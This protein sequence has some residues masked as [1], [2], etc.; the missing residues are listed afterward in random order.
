VLAILLLD[1]LINFLKV[2]ILTM[3][4]YISVLIMLLSLSDFISFDFSTNPFLIAG[5]FV[6]TILRIFNCNYVIKFGKKIF[7]IHM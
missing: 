3:I 6:G 7:T 5:L 2:N 4:F 1:L